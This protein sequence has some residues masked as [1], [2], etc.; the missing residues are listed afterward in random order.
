MQ[1]VILSLLIVTNPFAALIVHQ[2]HVT[3]N[4][5]MYPQQLLFNV[6]EIVLE[7][8]KTYNS[9]LTQPLLHL[10]QQTH[11]LNHHHTAQNFSHVP[12]EKIAHVDLLICMELNHVPLIVALIIH[13]T[14]QLEIMLH[15]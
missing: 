5:L 15:I 7:Q 10:F 8:Y 14:D 1:H 11:L 4:V 13:V 6:L 2:T 12:P 3:L 9:H